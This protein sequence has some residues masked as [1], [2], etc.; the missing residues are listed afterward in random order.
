M[1]QR[2]TN[3]PPELTEAERLRRLGEAY[4]DPA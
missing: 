4:R 3:P 2:A 1:T